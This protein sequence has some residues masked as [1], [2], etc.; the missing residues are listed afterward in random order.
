MK[1]RLASVA[2]GAAWRE[3]AE[4]VDAWLAERGAARRDAVVLVPFASLLPPARRAFAARAGWMPRVETTATLAASLGPGGPSAADRPFALALDGALVGASASRAPWAAGWTARD[5]RSFWRTAG[6]AARA[7]RTI[8][9]GL[10]AVHPAARPARLAALRAALLP[11]RGLDDRER[12]FTALAVEW[13]T[14]TLAGGDMP[15]DALW[16][17]RPSALVV[18]EAGGDDALAA[19]LLAQAEDDGTPTLV[20]SADP[21]DAAAPFD[22]VPATTVALGELDDF[23]DEAEAAAAAVLHHLQRGERP[24]ALVA[25]DREL[26]RRVRALLARQAV[27]VRDET[28]WKLSTTRAGAT[29]A[30]LLRALDDAA[31]SDAVIDWS[32]SLGTAWRADAS[33]LEAALR[34]GSVRVAAAIERQPLEQG[35]ERLRALWRDVKAAFDGPLE[36]VLPDWLDA[37]RAALDRAGQL[38]TLAA[39]D[40]GRQALAALRIVPPLQPSERQSALDV[41]R[42][43]RAAFGRIVD[44][45]LEAATFL[46]PKPVRARSEDASPSAA[47]VA[48]AV[49]AVA[50]V[51]AV[52]AA[53]AIP[54]GGRPNDGRSRIDASQLAFSFDA[55]TDPGPHDSATVT[56]ADTDTD[57]D[58]DADADEPVERADHELDVVVAPLGRLLLRPFAAAVLAGADAAH[59]GAVPVGNPL[60]PDAV[61]RVAGVDGAAAR[62]DRE[63]LAFAHLLRLPRT[64]LLR[65]R[66]DGVEVPGESAFVTELAVALEQRGLGLGRWQD[67][68]AAEP[69]EARPAARPAPVVP[70]ARLPARISASAIVS[71]RACPYQ[72]FV[73]RVL[74]ASEIGELDG[75]LAKR[76]YGNW[77]HAVLHRFHVERGPAGREA[78]A[79]EAALRAVADAVQA[80]QGIDAASLSPYRATFADLVP[81]YVRWLHDREREGARWQAGE[82]PHEVA[83]AGIEG[84]VLTGTVDRIDVRRTGPGPG[85]ETLDLLDY[86]TGN[87]EKLE[88]QAD[89]ADEDAQLAAYAALVAAADPRPIRAY[90]LPLDQ[91]TR[92]V[93]EREHVDVAASALAMVGDLVDVV[94]RVRAGAP[95]TAIGEGRACEWCAANGICRKAQWPEA[96]AAAVSS[97]GA[98]DTAPPAAA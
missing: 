85:G 24:V 58:T 38:A 91:P 10:A 14:A 37:L 34:R 7:A 68:R 23:E 45:V 22:E 48:S 71:L 11:P 53:A 49:A 78:A 76:E 16:S 41:G 30:G 51:A 6:E 88:K 19:G 47:T 15:T 32:K 89:D 40:A 97:D 50:A 18:V 94:G 73:R 62:R 43:D 25:Q 60:L 90:Y 52:T 96:E 77:L 13:A 83:L 66:S 39:D 84:V 27:T 12:A 64:T 35:A 93:R 28:G 92:G 55:E 98:S 70:A 21:S 9:A 80:E 56:L 4:R 1:H 63:R 75:E 82:V 36:R 54:K 8:E 2:P 29:V 3:V 46:P 95:L 69:V 81:A 79:D 26:V 57:T 44:E 20:L 17:L 72:F 67:P 65:R 87:A 86:K 33:D 59:L 42:I 5:P 74:N 31:G 61:A